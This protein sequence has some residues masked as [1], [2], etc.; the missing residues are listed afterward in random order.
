M[1]PEGAQ[2]VTI[3]GRLLR[4]THPDKVLYPATG[5]T[6]AD[7]IDYLVQIAPALLPHLSGRPVT[8]KRWVNGVGTSD[9][10]GDVFFEKNL[11]DSAPSWIR[12][13][14]M[15]HRSHRNVYPVFASVADLAWAGQVA[16]LELHVP[17]WRVD[18]LGEPLLPDRLVLDLD[19]GQGAGLAEAVQVA[20]AAR[21]L[22]ADV[23][24]EAVP[25]TSG[26]KGL[27][28][29]C[30]VDGTRDAGYLSSF[31]K[32]LAIALEEAHPDLVVSSMAKAKRG[33]KVLV[34]WS[35]NNGNKTTICP[36]SLRGREHP[37]VAVPRWWDELDDD[38]R[39]L[40]YEEVLERLEDLGDPLAA[41]APAAPD[42]LET[43][44]SM[45]DAA[46]TPEP[47]P[48]ERPRAR[49]G[50]EL[51]FVI[52]EHAA[53]RRHWDFRLERD[54][55]LVS[56]ALPKGVPDDPARNHLAVP[57]E[58]H[59]LEYATFHGDIP[60]GQYGAGHVE[61]WDTGTYT[62]GKWRDDEVI[63][64]LH[65]SEDGGLGGVARTFA[66]I[67]TGE[68]W[69]IHLMKDQH[70]DPPADIGFVRPMLATLADP[71]DIREGRW[72]FEMKWDGVRAII[73][74]EEDRTR[75][76]SRAGRDVTASYP[77]VADAI[78]AGVSPGT[79][80]DGEIVAL[81]DR[82]VPDFG[83]LQRRMGVERQREVQALVDEVPVTY[84]AFDLLAHEGRSLQ[85]AI[86]DERRRALLDLGLDDE[87]LVT[88]QAVTG[89]LDEA[90]EAS[91]RSKLEGVVA[92]RRDSRYVSGERSPAWLKIKHQ[93][94]QAVVIGGWRPG[95]PQGFGSLLVGIPG[96]EGL[97][98][99]GRVG[100]GF[101]DRQRAELS[102]LL[103]RGART[104]PPFVDV[105]DD[106]ASDAK[107]TSPSVVGEVV[108]AGWT[109]SG[110]L[111]HAVWRGMRKDLGPDDVHIES[112]E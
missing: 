56:W 4:L 78:R 92:K 83:L 80:L 100:T 52:Q 69:L 76:F 95:A 71:R 7:V 27:H 33:G 24:L 8:R 29:Y 39:Q 1:M 38:L 26:S 9:S 75:I 111:R 58:D 34:D 89:S 50:D 43:Y 54:G 110:I 88:P 23:G 46:A 18:D 21:E 45:R 97:R 74:V 10:P 5:T 85:D 30:A 79:V 99:V 65:G 53:R 81:D 51:G 82:A 48:A 64:T 73:A 42:R 108:Y 41:L 106:V 86:Y 14:T 19:P 55:V 67:R 98:Y 93:H 17:Q 90:I 12:R 77:E 66:L 87:I 32:Q 37:T 49:E 16:A 68:N 40:G 107:W 36:Y 31:A 72:A 94:A 101:S 57:T 63:A 13:V 2:T 62:A 91:R 6:K 11:P 102:V 104:T 59:P 47:V 35:Q 103:R 20:H 15:Q 105:P 25:V 28:L 84:L 44:R 70:A 96:P 60:K 109:G 3:D 61:I 22:L 112:K